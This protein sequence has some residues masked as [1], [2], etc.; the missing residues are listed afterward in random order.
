MKI[1]TSPLLPKAMQKLQEQG[2][3]VNLYFWSWGEVR[4]RVT[5]QRHDEERYNPNYNVLDT[6]DRTLYRPSTPELYG[7][8]EIAKWLA[9][10]AERGA[11]V[12]G[13]RV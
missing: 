5:D 4:L 3:N 9:D 12:F 6:Y 13:W 1:L 10:V 11:E 8:I 2:L 7:D